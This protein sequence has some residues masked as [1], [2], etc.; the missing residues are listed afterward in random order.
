MTIMARMLIMIYQCTQRSIEKWWLV[1][2]VLEGYKVRTECH[3]VIAVKREVDKIIFLILF[4]TLF[5]NT[6]YK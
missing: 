6:D 4:L 2:L 1:G 3:V 5:P